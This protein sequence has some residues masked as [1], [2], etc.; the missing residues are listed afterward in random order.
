MK[1]VRYSETAKQGE[2]YALLRE[3]SARL[4]D[5][6]GA[7]S[8][9]ATAEWGQTRDDQGRTLCTLRVSDWKGS[10]EA[11]FTPDELRQPTHLRFRLLQ[12]WGEV[13]QTWHHRLLKEVLAPGGG[14]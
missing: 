6:V 8:A 12:L 13:L 2:Y 11:A 1:D 5:A 7:S 10:A 9:S 3:A 4:E 14:A